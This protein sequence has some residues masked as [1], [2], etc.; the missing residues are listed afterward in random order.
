[1][2]PLIALIVAARDLAIVG[3]LHPFAAAAVGF[4]WAGWQMG[5]AKNRTAFS[6]IGRGII[7]GVAAWAVVAL[8]QLVIGGVS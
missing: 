3:L 1:M 8:V 7:S 6:E 2:E 5:A 4:F